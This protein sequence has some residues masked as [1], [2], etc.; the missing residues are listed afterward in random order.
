MKIKYPLQLNRMNDDKF[1]N[2]GRL[3]HSGTHQHIT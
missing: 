3:E 1:R 2:I